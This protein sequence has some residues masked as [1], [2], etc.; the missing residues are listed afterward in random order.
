M[1]YEDSSSKF[2][3]PDPENVGQSTSNASLRATTAP[4][5]A[6]TPQYLPLGGKANEHPL[7]PSSSGI[8]ASFP[9]VPRAANTQNTPV[10]TTFTAHTG[11]HFPG[12]NISTIGTTKTQTWS[13]HQRAEKFASLGPPIMNEFD[14]LH[15]GSISSNDGTPTAAV[16]YPLA[17]SSSFYHP[18]SCRASWKKR[19][20]EQTHALLLKGFSANYRGDPDVARNQSAPIREEESCSLWIVGLAPDLTTHELLSGIHNIG[21]VYA[22]H[23]NPPVPER[24]HTLSAAK[25]VFFERTAAELFYKTFAPTGYWTPRNPHLR[26]RVTWNRIRSA[27]VDVGGTRSRVLLI[28]GPPQVVNE[29]YLRIYFD[30]KFEYQIDQIIYRGANPAGTRVLLEFRFGSF[31]CQAESARTALMREFKDAGIVCEFGS[32]LRVLGV[33]GVVA[34]RVRVIAWKTGRTKQKV[35]D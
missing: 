27:E 23:I 12:S 10:A 25:V 9:W 29:D 22:T 17:S 2:N 26:A 34:N 8:A 4:V 30:T 11:Y 19:T 20:R 16:A 18:M 6:H 14:R 24:G 15:N 1:R 13:F 28:S 5:A 3:S 21:R 31:R 35:Y 7:V 32:G 33:L